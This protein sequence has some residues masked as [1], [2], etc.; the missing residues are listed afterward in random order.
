MLN[1]ILKKMLYN[2]KSEIR[3]KEE[4]KYE[5]DNETESQ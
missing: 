4:D 1:K 2:G 5:N 3:D